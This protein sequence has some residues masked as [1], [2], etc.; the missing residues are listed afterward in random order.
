MSGGL[1]A[2]TSLRRARL[3]VVWGRVGLPPPRGSV[4]AVFF[5]PEF[6]VEGSFEA[7]DGD[8]VP[9]C[10]AVEDVDDGLVTQAS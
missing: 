8:C 6:G 7:G 3:G 10:G 5:A 2:G 4:F 1:I 9:P